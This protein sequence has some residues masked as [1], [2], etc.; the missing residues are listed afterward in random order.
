M[1][2]S[3]LNPK[4]LILNS[5]LL[6]LLTTYC[7]L[8]AALAQ[9]PQ[10]QAGQQIFPINAK[11]VQ[12]FGPGYWPTAGSNLTLNLAPGTAVCSNVVRTFSGG[13]LTLAP[14]ATNYVY[15][16]P[17]SNCAPAS[18][19]TGFITGSIPIATVATTSTAISSVTDVRTLFVSNSTTG[20]VTSVGMTGD[21]IIFSSAVSGSPVTST[22]TLAPQLLIQTANTVLA[23]PSSGSPA[24]PT[25]RTLAPADLPASISSNTTGNAATATALAG[26]PAQCGSNNWVTGISSIGNANCLQPG[27]SNLAG[28]L[29]LGETPL[30][31]AGDILFVNSTPGLARL[32]IGGSNQFLGISG[33]LPAWTQPTFSNFGGT[34][35]VSQGGTGQT[36]GAA[37]FN[38][39]SPLTSEGD[40]PYYHSSTNGRL[41]VGGANTFLTSNGIDP[42][43]GSL[44]GVGFGT[45]TASTFLGAPAGSSGS[46]SFRALVAAD[47][48]TITIAGGGTGQTTASAAFNTLSPLSTEGDLLYYHASAN[49]RLAVGGNSQ[50]L[51]SNG[52]D[53]VWGSCSGSSSFAWSSLAVPA[54]NLTLSMS[55]YTTTFNHTSP[56]N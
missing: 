9:Q 39:L 31:V 21:G 56:V 34:A 43:W 55:G 40:M 29:V 1:R 24:T 28:S 41:A 37:A 18:N 36:T 17:A 12:G 27:F 47:L 8:P 22:G 14:S 26:T 33:G 48:P 11:Y 2:G 44:T 15:L 50:C 16:N 6:L 51:L 45:Q 54:A 10:A 42:S 25:F 20:S 53:P 30:S 38:A 4:S 13:T 3:G 19:T 52:T 32:P 5:T 7:L 35:A 49:T 46:P 23:G